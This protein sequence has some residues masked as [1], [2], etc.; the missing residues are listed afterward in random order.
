M[1]RVGRKGTAASVGL[2][3]QLS[4]LWRAGVKSLTDPS[5]RPASESVT[6]S[7]PFKLARNDLKGP[8]PHKFDGLTAVNDYHDV[9]PTSRLFC[10]TV[11]RDMDVNPEIFYGHWGP[12]A[13]SSA[14]QILLLFKAQFKP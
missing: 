9:L 12:F 5:D 4:K 7:G 6:G 14:S 10:R 2:A 8:G 1:G 11:E 3:A 13:I